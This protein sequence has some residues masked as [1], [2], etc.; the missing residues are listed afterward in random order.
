MSSHA[1]S[2]LPCVTSGHVVLGC[3]QVRSWQF[4]LSRYWRYNLSA[5]AQ[6]R[7]CSGRQDLRDATVGLVHSRSLTT[8]G[9]D[10][11]SASAHPFE[12]LAFSENYSALST[13]FSLLRLGI[14]HRIW[15]VPS[16]S[17]AFCGSSRHCLFTLTGR[18]PLGSPT[19]CGNC[20]P[21]PL[22]FHCRDMALSIR[23]SAS[24]SE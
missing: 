14:A 7:C 5:E 15:R 3:V 23:S 21:C 16:G 20:G 1:G 18:L 11:L 8:F 12:S 10:C 6:D 22:L 13:L 19:L 24:L 17:A 4:L 9:T 2:L